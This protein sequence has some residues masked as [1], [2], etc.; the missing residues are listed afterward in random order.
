MKK[1]FLVVLFLIA[2]GL[3]L[4]AAERLGWSAPKLYQNWLTVDDIS[5]LLHLTGFEVI[6]S[7]QEILLPLYMPYISVFC[8]RFLVRLWPFRNFALTNFILARPRVN[9]SHSVPELVVSVVV[10][11]RNEAGTISN[12]FERT[13]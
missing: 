8:N 5:G 13:P 10:P 7:W 3:P 9:F 4:K 1:R 11:A 2:V 6:R 12:I